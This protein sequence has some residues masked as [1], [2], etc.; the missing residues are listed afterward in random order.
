MESVPERPTAAAAAAALRD[1]ESSRS[2]IARG[3]ATPSWFFTSIACAV[4][5]QIAVTAAALRDGEGGWPLVAGMAL[6]VVVGGVQL[7]RLRRLN[8]VWIGGL[9]SRVVLGSS[10]TATVA[11]IPALTVAIWAAYDAR[12]WLVAVSS[13]AG[14]LG[15]AAAGRRWL[16]AYRGDPAAHARGES[17][18]WLAVLAAVAIAGLAL[19]LL[20]A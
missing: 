12:W 20:T 11:Y 1:A 2:E 19:L 14:G 17:A 4:A 9:A 10:A 15:Y 7:A 8:G 13:I 16:R 6:A 5:A 3:I 18:V